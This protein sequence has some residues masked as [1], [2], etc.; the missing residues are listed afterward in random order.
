LR[1][2]KGS[3]MGVSQAVAMIESARVVTSLFVFMTCPLE[4]EFQ[5]VCPTHVQPPLGFEDD[6]C[7]GVISPNRKGLAPKALTF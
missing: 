4:L 5:R 7:S 6:K 3:L 2:V 1:A